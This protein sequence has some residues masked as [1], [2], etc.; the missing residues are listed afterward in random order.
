MNHRIKLTA[1]VC[2]NFENSIL[3]QFLSIFSWMLVDGGWRFVFGLC[4]DGVSFYDYTCIYSNN[5]TMHG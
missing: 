3:T 5:L 2:E 1:G 4:K